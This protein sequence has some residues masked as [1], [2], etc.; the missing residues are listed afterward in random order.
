MSSGSGISASWKRGQ[1]APLQEVNS[2][3]LELKVPAPVVGNAE[4]R[5]RWWGVQTR[6]R[7]TAAPSDEGA[8]VSR[9]MSGVQDAGFGVGGGGPGQS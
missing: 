9:W 3:H 8:C 6:G 1:I 4:L 7:K 2:E 5:C